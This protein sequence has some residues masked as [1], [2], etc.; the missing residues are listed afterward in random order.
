MGS[1]EDERKRIEISS[2]KK[3]KNSS[4]S[5]SL[6]LSLSSP[7]CLAALTDDVAQPLLLPRVGA[8]TKIRH[9]DRRPGVIL[10]R[11]QKVLRLQVPVDDAHLV[12]V[13]QRLEHRARASGGAALAELAVAG[14]G[15]E[16]LAALA[17]LDDEV[18]CLI[19]FFLKKRGEREE[20][21]C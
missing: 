7:H 8:Q 19:F 2:K 20:R 11:Q 18:D 15:L 10:G 9:L 4:L 3:N 1:K 17:E 13:A 6:S 5:L 16:E 21:E 12:E 14:D